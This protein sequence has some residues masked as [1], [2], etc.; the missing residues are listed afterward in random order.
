MRSRSAPS[1][2]KPLTRFTL[3]AVMTLVGLATVPTEGADG[4][5]ERPKPRVQMQAAERWKLRPTEPVMPNTTGSIRTRPEIQIPSDRRNVRL[6][7]P[8]LIE[9][10]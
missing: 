10:R 7:Y 6:V 5:L 3:L 8:A 9:P 2:P 1:R 4:H